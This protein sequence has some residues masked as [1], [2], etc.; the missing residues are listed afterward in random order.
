MARVGDSVENDYV[1]NFHI[2]VGD[3]PGWKKPVLNIISNDDGS[4]ASIPLSRKK[5]DELIAFGIGTEG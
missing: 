5:A 2:Q 3:K 4:V 1:E